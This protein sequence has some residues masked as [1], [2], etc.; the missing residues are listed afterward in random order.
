[1]EYSN[2]GVGLEH[3]PHDVDELVVLL[4]RDGLEEAVQR[5]LA[6]V[7]N[8]AQELL[9][10]RHEVEHDGL[11][12]VLSRVVEDGLA[13]AVY[14]SGGGV[15]RQEQL[16]NLV[17]PVLVT[18]VLQEVV[19]ERAAFLGRDLGAGLVLQK[20]LDYILGTVLYREE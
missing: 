11:E 3:H 10:F 8:G 5:R 17:D 1:M 20:K 2:G 16:V 13:V 14:D 18:G 9:H 12:L 15:F 19:Q 4:A 6:G 7:V